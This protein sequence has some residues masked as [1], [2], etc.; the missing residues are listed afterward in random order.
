MLFNSRDGTYRVKY[1]RRNNNDTSRQWYNN[2]NNN[3]YTIAVI[4]WPYLIVEVVN[5]LFDRRVGVHIVGSITNGTA[6]G[7]VET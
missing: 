3:D 5:V 1:E 7:R 2:N 6:T 4:L